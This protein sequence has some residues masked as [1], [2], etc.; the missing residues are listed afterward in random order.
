M[1][2][3]YELKERYTVACLHCDGIG[4]RSCRGGEVPVYVL[5]MNEPGRRCR[6]RG[7]ILFGNPAHVERENQLPKVVW[8]QRC[9]WRQIQTDVPEA[10]SVAG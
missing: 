3:E 9:E 8:C 1:A 6:K 10:Y 2:D 5:E 4:C 7:H